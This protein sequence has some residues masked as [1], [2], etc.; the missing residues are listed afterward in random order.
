[1]IKKLQKALN[2]SRGSH[3][4]AMWHLGPHGSATWAHAA[5]TRRY[6]YIYLL[7][8]YSIKG[9]QPSIYRKGYSNPLIRRA[10]INPTVLPNLFCVGLKSHTVFQLQATWSEERR[11]IS[12][13][14]KIRASIAWTGGPPDQIRHVLEIQEL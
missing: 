7:L 4:D 1:M 11:R 3:V 9:L 2:I 10:F 8:L 13:A 6:I 14:S 12:S 5:P